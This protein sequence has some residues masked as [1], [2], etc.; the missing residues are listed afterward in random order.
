MGKD[1]THRLQHVRSVTCAILFHSPYHS[2]SVS[3]CIVLRNWEHF[4]DRNPDFLSFFRSF[5][6]F[7]FLNSAAWS[8]TDAKTF[9]ELALFPSGRPAH[10]SLLSSIF[11]HPLFFPSKSFTLL[12]V[13]IKR[14]S[15]K[16]GS[17]VFPR[18][19]VLLFV[20]WSSK[21]A[22]ARKTH[23]SLLYRHNFKYHLW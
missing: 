22:Q 6:F 11:N 14:E 12:T 17:N 2:L 21:K 15:E 18:V 23:H 1:L 5:F 7:F 3:V 19:A 9:L 10:S 13:L 4:N 8:D 16:I 20:T